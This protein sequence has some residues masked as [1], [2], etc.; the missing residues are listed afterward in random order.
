MAKA[1]VKKA[2]KKPVKKTAAKK[3]TA[4]KPAAPA[5]DLKSNAV[6]SKFEA[7]MGKFAMEKRT[8][9]T[10]ISFW[11]E[12]DGRTLRLVT[13]YPK[14]KSI[15]MH[16]PLPGIKVKGK[17]FSGDVGQKYRYRGS[18][19]KLIDQ[20]VKEIA[21]AAKKAPP[22]APEKKKPAKKA[23]KKTAGKKP[24]KKAVKN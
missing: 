6:V 9:N 19:E 15:Y 4:K 8:K 23:A 3:A 2:V 1:P 16:T 10:A 11:R 14:P 21:V 22:P 5:V 13:F 12:H 7:A 18:D 20:F 17:G 24:V